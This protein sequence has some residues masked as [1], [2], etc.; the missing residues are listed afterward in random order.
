[1]K[2]VQKGTRKTTEERICE[3]D[4]FSVWSTMHRKKAEGVT[5][6]ESKGVDCDEV[7]CAG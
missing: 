4:E 2:A 1:V 6:G 5:D 3:R 7:I